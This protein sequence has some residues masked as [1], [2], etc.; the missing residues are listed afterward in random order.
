MASLDER[1]ANLEAQTDTH[2]IAVTALR[3]DIADLR[4]ELRTQIAAIRGEM[5]LR[6]EVSEL[7]G[8]MNRRFDAMDQKFTWLTGTQVATLLAVVGILAGALFR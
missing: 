6:S 5:A 7:R 4:V 2:A 3:A 8:E 1:V